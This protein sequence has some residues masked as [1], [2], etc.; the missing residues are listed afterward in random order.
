MYA[1]VVISL[2]FGAVI[3]MVKKAD[4][5][6]TLMR[7]SGSSSRVR[8][9]SDRHTGRGTEGHLT[10][11]KLINASNS[12]GACEELAPTDKAKGAVGVKTV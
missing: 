7:I 11:L 12:R 8:P 5:E 2:M 9:N 10:R 4:K 6:M 1:V 3:V